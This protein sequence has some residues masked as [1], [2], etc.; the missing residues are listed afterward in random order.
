MVKVKQIVKNNNEKRLQH[1]QE[2]HLENAVAG[3]EEIYKVGVLF[4]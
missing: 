3:E 2:Y 4:Y 1:H